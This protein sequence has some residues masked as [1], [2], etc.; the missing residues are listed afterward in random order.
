MIKNQK[1]FLQ[2]IWKSSKIRFAE[3]DKLIKEGNNLYKKWEKYQPKIECDLNSLQKEYQKSIILHEASELI[4]KGHH[5]RDEAMH[6][7]IQVLLDA[8]GNVN[9][10]YEY[11][12]NKNNWTING[13]T[14]SD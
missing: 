3:A 14:Y 10:S 12:S 8:H 4:A 13:V 9:Y 1:D 5:L 7:W 2:K 6:F 11:R